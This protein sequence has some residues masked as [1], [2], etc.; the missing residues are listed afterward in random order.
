MM[1]AGRNRDVHYT[2]YH[3]VKCTTIARIRRVQTG[4][5]INSG[6]SSQKGM[7][8]S[9]GHSPPLRSSI[10]DALLTAF[11][12][13]GYALEGKFTDILTEIMNEGQRQFSHWVQEGALG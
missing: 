10:V 6:H 7:S 11:D 3:V 9:G 13:Q 1:Q 5:Y 12:A 4:S 8:Q 2:M